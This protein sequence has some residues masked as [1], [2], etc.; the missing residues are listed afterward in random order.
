MQLR[1]SPLGEIIREV[2]HSISLSTGRAISARPSEDEP[3]ARAEGVVYG[4]TRVWIRDGGD[5]R[6]GSAAAAGVV[7][8]GGLR[9][10]GRAAAAC[11]RPR[12]LT[13]ATRARVSHQRG[14]SHRRHML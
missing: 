11:A 4:N 1:N 2:R 3:A 12:G 8:P 5:V 13:P 14:T 6:H 9:D 7:L 10:V